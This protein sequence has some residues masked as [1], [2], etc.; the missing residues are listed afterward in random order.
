MTPISL[1][2]LEH[3]HGDHRANAADLNGVN[4]FRIAGEIRRSFAQIRD[5]DWLAAPR[6]SGMLA[7]RR[8]AAAT[9]RP[10]TARPRLSSTSHGARRRGALRL[11]AETACRSCAANSHRVIQDSLKTGS[12]RRRRADDAQHIRRGLPAAL[13]IRPAHVRATQSFCSGVGAGRL[14]TRRASAHCGASARPSYVAVFHGFAVRCARAQSGYAVTPFA[15][16]DSLVASCLPPGFGQA[17]VLAQTGLLEGPRSDLSGSSGSPPMSDSGENRYRG[18]ALYGRHERLIRGEIMRL[19]QC[20]NF[21]DFRELA[22][23]RLPG[24]IFN[25]IDGAADDETTYRRNTRAFEDCDLVP[26]VLAGVEQVDLSVTVLGSK[27]E[28]AVLLLADRFAPAVSPSGRARRGARRGKIRHDVRRFLAGHGEP[29]RHRERIF[30]FRR[31]IS[32]TFT[33]IAG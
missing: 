23:R 12:N 21:H 2:V 7:I 9:F 31:S 3:R 19:N 30:R 24:P 22:R 5:L 10:A 27:I 33:R 15:D 13:A 18:N 14:A 25:Y 11:R 20:H 4:G 29:G 8:R 32:S 17:I 28:N 26:S 6:V 1:A 16:R